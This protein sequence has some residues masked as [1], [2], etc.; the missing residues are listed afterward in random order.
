MNNEFINVAICLKPQGIKGE[1][2]LLVLLDDNKD[3]L[4]F[5]N[6]YTDDFVCHKIQRVFA[7]GKDFAV[8]LEGIDSVNDAN[9]LKN[10]QKENKEIRNK[11]GSIKHKLKEKEKLKYGKVN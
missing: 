2:K 10:K 7:V 9:F 11:K 3:I 8:K 6:L 4:K 5:E 1:I